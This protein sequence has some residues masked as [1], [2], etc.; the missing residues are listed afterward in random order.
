MQ[1]NAQAT[2]TVNY[3]MNYQ[4]HMANG[5][6]NSG[7]NQMPASSQG[8]GHDEAAVGGGARGQGYMNKRIN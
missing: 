1:Y 7:R 6:S 4:P 5:R 8:G 2:K 3:D